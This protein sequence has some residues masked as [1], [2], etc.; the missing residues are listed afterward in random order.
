MS[1]TLNRIIA[2]KR[3]PVLFI[4]SGLSKRYLDNYPSWEQLLDR[5]RETIGISKPAYAAKQHEIKSQNPNISQGKLNQKMA[6]YLQEKLLHKI[7]ND[8]INVGDIFTEEENSNCI[9]SGVDY[10]KMLVAKMLTEYTVKADKSAELKLLQKISEKISMVFTTNYDLF[11]QNE[12]FK[13]FKVYESQD[14]YY[15]RTNNGYG[16]LYKIHGCI[17]DPNG[18]IICEKDYE[19]FESSLKLVSSKLLNALMDCPIIFLGYSLEDENIKKIMT[20]FVSSFD[21]AILQDIKK[22]I[23]LVVYEEGQENLIEGEKQFADDGSGKSITLTTIK[24]DNFEKLYEHID[25]LTP[26]A[27]TYELRK[28]KTMVADLINKTAKGENRIFVQEIDNAK[29]DAM[30]LYIGSRNSIE[31]I[32]KSVSIFDTGD[33]IKKALYEE[34]FDYDSFASVWYDSKGIASTEYTPVFLIKHEMSV[35]FESCGSKFKTNYNSRK[36]FFDKLVLE[37]YNGNYSTISRKYGLLKAEKRNTASVCTSICKDLELAL[38][39]NKISIDECFAFMKEILID[40][41][42]A[43]KVSPFKRIACFAWYMKYEKKKSTE[44]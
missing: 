26:A 18:I 9:N 20:D 24:T 10:F 39:N 30:A 28:Y 15:F 7:E 42:D 8:S 32:Q 38:Y 35:P 17:N 3:L 40:F 41:P 2:S 25:R 43:I 21:N 29:T 6:S 36:K 11:L 34:P 33:I 16:E 1:E 4:G 31:G 23:I 19:K 12:I 27:S 37:K 14:K 13:D 44:G 22:Y 5:L